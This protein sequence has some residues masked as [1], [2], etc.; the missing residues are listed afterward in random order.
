LK[1]KAALVA[2]AAIEAGHEPPPGTE[3]NL[4]EIC[5]PMFACWGR[6]H[7]SRHYMVGASLIRPIGLQYSEVVAYARAHGFADS[8]AELAEFTD[9]VYAADRAFLDW[10]AETNKQ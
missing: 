5:E 2:A 1:G 10:W 8:I 3:Y 4:W 6:L 7:W 9:L